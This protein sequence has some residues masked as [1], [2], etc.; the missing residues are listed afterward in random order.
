MEAL[1]T[2]ASSSSVAF[3]LRDSAASSSISFNFL[4]HSIC[5]V[6]AF[7]LEEIV[8][9]IDIENDGKQWDIIKCVKINQNLYILFPDQVV[10]LSFYNYSSF[11]HTCIYHILT[12]T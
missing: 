4:T 10:I 9:K 6:E 3:D 8:K 11:L 7:L 1:A 5:L 2:A 12:L